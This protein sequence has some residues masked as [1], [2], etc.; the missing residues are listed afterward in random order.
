MLE[1]RYAPMAVLWDVGCAT[2]FRVSDLLRLTVSDV[3]NEHFVIN[4]HLS[5]LER[6]TKKQRT[7]LLPQDIRALICSYVQNKGYSDSH[8]LWPYSRQHVWRLFKLAG[9]SPHSMRKTYAWI[10]LLASASVADVQSLMLHQFQSTTLQYLKPGLEFAVN[11]GW[12]DF[13]A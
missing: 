2:G 11:S 5:I 10:Q 9:V 3:Q 4:T 12:L 13:G 8:L 1:R 7:I 6:K